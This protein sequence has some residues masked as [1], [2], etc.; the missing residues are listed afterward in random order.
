MHSVIA[1]HHIKQFHTGVDGV[2]MRRGDADK[3]AKLSHGT[4]KSVHFGGATGLYI[5]KH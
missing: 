2:N 3:A 1:Y 5:L 4:D